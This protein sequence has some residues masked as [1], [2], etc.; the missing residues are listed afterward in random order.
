MARQAP[1]AEVVLAIFVDRICC[2]PAAETAKKYGY[3]QKTISAISAKYKMDELESD[4]RTAII[5]QASSI[6]PEAQKI[7]AEY[8]EKL[9]ELG[10][11][12]LKFAGEDFDKTG[13][14]ELD[15]ARLMQVSIKTL[16]DT[17]QAR[18]KIACSNAEARKKEATQDEG[19]SS[20]YD[21]LVND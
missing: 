16:E 11:K 15:R 7:N 19:Q 3:Q 4:V 10:D 18:V 9:A 12:M 17:R 14:N 5:G 8:D 21:H 20:A 1:P 6:P 2:V 13:L